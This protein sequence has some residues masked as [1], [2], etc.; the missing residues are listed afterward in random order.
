[1]QMQ[2]ISQVSREFNISTRTLR[3]YEQIGLI[4]PAKKEDGFCRVYDSNM[5]LRLRQILVLRKLRIPLKQIA[6]IINSCDVQTAIEIFE[7]NLQSVE[8]EMNSLSEIRETI[9]AFLDRLTPG[10][11]EISLLQDE[12]LLEIADSLTL[13]NQTVLRHLDS[14]ALCSL[15]PPRAALS[16]R[17]V[18]I[19]YLPP[20]AVA[21]YQYV[22]DEP[23]T[24]ANHVIDAFVRNSDLVNKKPDLRH[25]G[26]NAPNPDDTGYHGYEV[27]VTIPADMEIE[28]PLVKKYFCGG[29]YAVH[30][31][32]FGAFEEWGMLDKWVQN[33]EKYQSNTGNKGPECMFGL[34]EEHLNY[35]NHVFLDNT[36]PDDLQMDLLYPVRVKE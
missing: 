14:K 12:D 27:W 23:E 6:E 33:S 25:Y 18:R 10:N 17:E 34:L 30:T 11:I 20:S 36:E 28:E 5:I 22:G 21:S 4:T 7:K 19:L 15:T 35:R 3:Y 9:R 13:S 16:E 24:H 31:I 8:D 2:T 1:M 29:L 26:F 32:P